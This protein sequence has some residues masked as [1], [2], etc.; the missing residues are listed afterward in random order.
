[1]SEYTRT[2]VLCRG[3]LLVQPHYRTT[4]VY[5]NSVTQFLKFQLFATSKCKPHVS[6]YC[7]VTVLHSAIIGRLHA[8]IVSTVLQPPPPSLGL[9]RDSPIRRFAISFARCPTVVISQKP[10]SWDNINSK[11]KLSLH[12]VHQSALFPRPN[13]C[14]GFDSFTYL[15]RT[16]RQCTH[17]RSSTA[18]RYVSLGV[19]AVYKQQ[20]IKQTSKAMRL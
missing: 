13:L 20:R 9:V 8:C 3:I 1:M 11:S 18:Y 4:T 16:G 12:I 6:L 7:I 5:N 15:V 10:G 14:T 2:S 17:H 19:H